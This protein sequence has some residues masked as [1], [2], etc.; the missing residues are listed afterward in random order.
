MDP[1]L[2]YLDANDFSDLSKPENELSSSDKAILELLRDAKRNGAARFFVSPVHLSEAVHASD[3][4]KDAAVRRATL[5]QELGAGN[6]LQ[7]PLNICKIELAR[8]FADGGRVQCS[9][10]EVTSKPNEWFGMSIPTDN[11]KERRTEIDAKIDTALRNLNRAERRRQKSKLNPNKASSQLYIRSLVKEGL[12]QPSSNNFP[13]DLMNPDLVLNWYLGDASD[14]E[15]RKNSVRVL[16]DPYLLFKYFIDEFGHRESLYRVIRDQGE[17]WVSLVDTATSQAIPLL[18]LAKQSGNQLD[19]KSTMSQITS[20]S[21]WRKVIGSLAEIDL[22]H[23]QKKEIEEA[24]EKSPSTSIFI[25]ILLESILVKLQSTATR[26]NSGNLK[27]ADAKVSDYADFMHAIYAPYFD[28]FRC[29][30]RIG[31]LTPWPPVM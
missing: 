12:S 14:E 13:V 30:T 9:L 10:A 6:I 18:V 27:P 24:K 2:V 5:M 23:L 25:H 15:F 22:G 11:L 3:T 17:K 31:E 1:K 29:D 4:Y 7:F 8:A 16:S 28:I 26:V 19:L 20:E 21:F